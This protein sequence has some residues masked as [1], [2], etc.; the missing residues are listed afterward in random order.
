MYKGLLEFKKN[1][2]ARTNGRIEVKTYAREAWLFILTVIAEILL[3]I[4]LP[5]VVLFVPNLVFGAG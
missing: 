4:F 1:V 3:M 5:E 2:E